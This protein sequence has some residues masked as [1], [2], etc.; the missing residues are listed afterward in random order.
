MKRIIFS[1]LFVIFSVTSANACDDWDLIVETPKGTF[2]VDK[3]VYMPNEHSWFMTIAE[4]Y[5]HE[6]FDIILPCNWVKLYDMDGEITEEMAK[7]WFN[8]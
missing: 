3:V 2:F 8:N 6:Y 1:L 7:T 4:D 5:E